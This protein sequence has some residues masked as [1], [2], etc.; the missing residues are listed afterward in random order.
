MFKQLHIK[1]IAALLISFFASSL[2]MKEVFV[3]EGPKIRPDLG[4]YLTQ[5]L[6]KTVNNNLQFL[7]RLLRPDQ[8]TAEE[9]LKNT[10]LQQ[11]SKGVYAKSNKQASYT[12]YKDNEIEWIA[13]NFNVNGKSVV[14]RVPRGQSPPPKE[15]IEIVYR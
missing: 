4:Q 5:L 1:I 2:L 11:V 15:L 7:S 9:I 8:Q 3:A 14:I 10:P 12:L 13:Y 6:D